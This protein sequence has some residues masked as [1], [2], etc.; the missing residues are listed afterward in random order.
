MREPLLDRPSSRRTAKSLWAALFLL[1]LA[2]A[3]GALALHEH[4]APAPCDAPDHTACA[5]PNVGFE[6]G[7]AA[8]A[9]PPGAA[10]LEF[11]S[12][13]C[14]ACRKLEPVLADARRQCLRAGTPVVRID[15]DNPAAGAL[16]SEWQVMATPTLVFLDSR[17]EET[18]RIVGA[19]SLAGVRRVIEQAY[20]LE[21]AALRSDAAP[22]G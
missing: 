4:G 10:V 20:G 6:H 15:I 9:I 16:A 11:T 12:E 2:G 17:H 21:C 8:I 14:P 18:A 3:G 22:P 19:Q 5:L 7:E 13:Y 1:C